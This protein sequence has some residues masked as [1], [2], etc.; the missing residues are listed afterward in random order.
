MK[1]LQ[2]KNFVFSAA[3]VAVLGIAGCN[4]FNPT[5]DVN[6]KSDDAAALT[7]EGYLHFQKN[8]YTLAREYFEKA[9]AADSSYSEAWYGRAKAVL[10]MQPGMNIFELLS[11]AKTDGGANAMSKFATMDEA[12]AR[13]LAKGIDSVMY[14]IDPLI[15]L[16]QAGKTDGK[17]KFANYSSSYSILKIAKSGLLLRGSSLDVK[18]LLVFDGNNINVNINGILEMGENMTDVLDA[19]EGMIEGLKEN[20]DQAYNV[21]S[22]VYP[23]VMENFT[24]TAVENA[25]EATFNGIKYTNDNLKEAGI[26]RASVFATNIGIDDDGDGCVDEE[27]LD[28]FDND[29]DGEID[30]DLRIEATVEKFD[31]N[32]MIDYYKQDDPTGI[33]FFNYYTTHPLDVIYAVKPT[34]E[35]ANVDVN[36]D[37]NLY[38]VDTT[39]FTFYYPEH[40]DRKL[41]GNHLFQFAVNLNWVKAPEGEKVFY[42]KEKL[43]KDPLNPDYNL[44]WRQKHIGGCW[45]NYKSELDNSYLLW[46]EYQ[47]MKKEGEI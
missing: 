31:V 7:Y 34:E 23:D 1:Y 18:N 42:Y 27:V 4:L 22:S 8:E 6:I 14:Y 41:T 36:G 15:K 47:R 26:D 12:Q 45:N 20:P 32:T 28:G 40:R 43:R 39:E 30:E 37:G 24:P 29:G 33:E 9:I 35:T 21:L 19:V 38:A 25:L 2:A 10:N 5:E 3:M 16:E 46:M 17:V 13:L 11:Y 44:A